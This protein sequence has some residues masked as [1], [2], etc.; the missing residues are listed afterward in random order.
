MPTC[1]VERAFLVWNQVWPISCSAMRIS[2]MPSAEEHVGEQAGQAHF[3][4]LNP[5][6]R[7]RLRLHR[8]TKDTV[9]GT[10]RKRATA[11]EARQYRGPL[12]Q[13][14][15]P[16]SACRRESNPPEAGGEWLQKG[17]TMWPMC[18]RRQRRDPKADNLDPPPA[19]TLP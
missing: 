15:R 9:N 2:S 17:C 12:A 8:S 14:R 7:I 16:W 1:S 10:H 11:L 3:Q 18:P 4:Q 19:R 5:V 6:S 13:C